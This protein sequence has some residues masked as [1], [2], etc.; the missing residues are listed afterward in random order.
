MSTEDGFRLAKCRKH[1]ANLLST[2]QPEGEFAIGVAA[3]RGKVVQPEPGI[4]PTR[5][6]LLAHDRRD[7]R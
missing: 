3:E 1:V 4:D 2:D 6:D 7:L 5:A